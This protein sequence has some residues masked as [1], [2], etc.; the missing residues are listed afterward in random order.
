MFPTLRTLIAVTAAGLTLIAQPALAEQYR[1][2]L[3][4]PPPHQWNKSAAAIAEKLK[5]ETSGRIEIMIFPAG[6]MG[7]E[8][9][10]LQQLQSGAID[11]AFM[12]VGEFANR[13]NDYAALMAPYIARDIAGAGKLL[14]GEVATELSA[15][16]AKIGLKGLGWGLA[17]MREVVM[18]GKV[19]AL[20][21]L[22]G[23]KIRT[24]PIAPELD[25]W[26]RVGATPTPIPLPALYDAFANRQVDG[27]QIDFEGT[28]NSKY[29]D[30]AGTIIHSDH[31]IFPMLAVASGRK[32]VRIPPADQTLIARAVSEELDRMVGI[33]A[34]ID[35]DYLKK[36]EGTGVPVIR[37]DRAFFGL[38][39][40]GWYE[41]WRVKAPALVKLEAEAAA[42]RD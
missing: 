18:S 21:E 14:H 3:I 5:A 23:K 36:L 38:A 35:A 41:A 12:T 10:V 42:L 37:A 17:G 39:V 25:F 7:T 28:W 19:A 15:R 40:D 4:T 34:A 24:V 1:M 29:S 13:D 16:A 2:A 22:Q 31:M 27:M 26:T 30:H 11:F 33:Y 32:W 6:Q 8:A 20:A 9:Q